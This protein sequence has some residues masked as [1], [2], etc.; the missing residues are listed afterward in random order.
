MKKVFFYVF[1]F[2]LSNTVF[3]QSNE[4]C[5]DGTPLDPSIGCVNQ[6]AGIVSA[7]SNLNDLFTKLASFFTLAA[8]GIAIIVLIYA[9]I[10]YSLALGDEERTNQA[11]RTLKWGIL[12]FSL[13]ISAYAFV[14]FVLKNII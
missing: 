1:Y 14:E 8:G 9:G 10:Q 5:P 6:P 12:G 2:F 7:N 3:A 13:A 4:F 11:K